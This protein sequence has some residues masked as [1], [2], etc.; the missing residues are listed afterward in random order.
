MKT[1]LYNLKNEK[2]GEVDLSDRVFAREWNAD[3]VH[4]A[5]LAQ[6]G[7]S[8]QTIAHAKGR[9]EVRGGGKKPWRQKGTGRARHGSIRS[10][11]W[12]GGGVTFGPT[13]ERNFSKKINKKMKRASFACV[14]SKKLKEDNLKIV[15]SLNIENPKT[16]IV[17]SAISGLFNKK[18]TSILLVP[19]AEN[20]GV[21]LA[22]RNIEGVKA[23]SPN[24]LNVVDLLK[25][26][27]IV[28]DKSAVEQVEKAVKI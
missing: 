18:K 8:R 11:L 1:D 12:V 7:N 28:L 4:Q 5:L 23:V 3:L 14:L 22:A 16:K 2:I 13:K 9:G 20:R 27:N 19:A 24:A 6:L 15:D 21:R 25:H 10:P 26:K 17:F